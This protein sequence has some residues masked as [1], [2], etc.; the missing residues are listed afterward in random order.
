LRFRRLQLCSIEGTTIF[1][2]RS[3]LR[4]LPRIHSCRF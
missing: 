4:H 3:M 1:E 2:T